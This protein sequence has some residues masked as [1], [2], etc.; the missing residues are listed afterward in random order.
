MHR[1][2]YVARNS[3]VFARNFRVYLSHSV[4]YTRFR[5]FYAA[6]AFHPYA[7]NSLSMDSLHNNA[8]AG[9]LASAAYAMSDY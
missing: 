7:G 4:P 2:P 1:G 6:L 5:N 9:N 3:N 8:C